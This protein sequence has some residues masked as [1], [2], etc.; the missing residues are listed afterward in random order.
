MRREGDAIDYAIRLKDRG[1]E[2]AGMR[3]RYRPAARFAPAPPGSLEHWL[4]E[5]Y[6]LYTQAPRGRIL[7]T[8]IHHLPWSIAAAE[9]T[10]ETGGLEPA[11]LGPLNNPPILHLADRQDV[12]V[13]PPVRTR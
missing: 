3:V 2:P 6:Y 9:A 4:V 1:A 5:R 12:L 10:I 11:A 7:R 13:W 8:D